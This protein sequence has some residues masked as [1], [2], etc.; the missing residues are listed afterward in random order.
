MAD[1]QQPSWRK[2]S[3]ERECP[4]TQRSENEPIRKIFTP[5]RPATARGVQV[6]SPRLKMLTC[7]FRAWTHGSSLPLAGQSGSTEEYPRHDDPEYVMAIS[8][9]CRVLTVGLSR[10]KPDHTWISCTWN[11]Q[12]FFFFHFFGGSRWWKKGECKGTDC[13]ISPNPEF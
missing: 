8:T 1:G 10:I 7:R 2:T 12:I 13:K 11:G 9:V 4:A 3:T 5:G 6:R